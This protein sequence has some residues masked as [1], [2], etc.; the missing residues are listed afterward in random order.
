MADHPDAYRQN[1]L[2]ASL[3]ASDLALLK[4]GLIQTELKQET[5]LHDQNDEIETVYFPHSGMVS[6]LAVMD[7]GTA[8]EVGTA[9]RQGMVGAPA[10]LGFKLA[11]TR[12]VVQLPGQASKISARLFRAAVQQSAMLKE[13]IIR[14]KEALLV[15]TQHIAACNSLH[16]VEARLCRWIL[17]SSDHID[18]EQIPL[19]Q[20]F[21]AEMLG[22][23]RTTVTL[24][25]ATLQK[26]GLINYR[27]GKIQII[28]RAGLEDMV[29]EC[30]RT[31]KDRVTKILL[32]SR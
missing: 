23:R 25:A 11:S 7:D 18:S 9:G 8:I 5:L 28:D 26:A 22:V 2:L 3:P 30:Y 27:R 32:P 29:C 20:E 24:A 31:T 21:L 14:H 17:Q 16:K 19:T 4:P 12:A 15:Q 1:L 6:L 13:M 10:G